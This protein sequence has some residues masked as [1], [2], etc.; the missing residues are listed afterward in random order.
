MEIHVNSGEIKSGIF[1]A[2]SYEE[3]TPGCKKTVKA[4]SDAPIHEDLANA[5]QKLLPH[6]LLVSEFK[7]KPELVKHFDLGTELP[8]EITSKFKVHSF[9]LEEKNSEISV[10]ITG[11]KNLSTGKRLP[12]TPPK[13]SRGSGENEYEFFTHLLGVVEELKGEIVEFMDGKMGTR[14]QIDMDFGEDD[15]FTPDEVIEDHAA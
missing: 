7:G 9:T 11:S 4:G 13:I 3:H 2:W 10:K 8:E 15:D 12:I 6:M 5:F 1:L 14:A